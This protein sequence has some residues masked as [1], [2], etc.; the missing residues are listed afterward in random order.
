MSNNSSN[1]S[2]SINS[3]IIGIQKIVFYP[4]EVYALHY[5][6]NPFSISNISREEQ[7]KLGIQY[8][9]I[10]SVNRKCYFT[11]GHA[12][13]GLKHLPKSIIEMVDIVKYIPEDEKSRVT[14]ASLPLFANVN[15]DRIREKQYKIAKDALEKVLEILPEKSY[16]KRKNYSLKQ[17]MLRDIFDTVDKAKKEIEELW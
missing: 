6:G 9:S 7:R 12:K 5:K 11:E 15:D 4:Q 8:P 14:S 2:N 10:G 16:F 13:S 3:E 1:S 17:D